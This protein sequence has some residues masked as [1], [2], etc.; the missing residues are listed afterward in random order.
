MEEVRL[1]LRI[2][3]SERSE[4]GRRSQ[5]LCWKINT[6]SPLD[7]KQQELIQELFCNQIGEG[8][9]LH[10]PVFVNLGRNVRI[11]RRCSI[12]NGFQC[13]AA[14]GLIIEDDVLI[15]LNCT[16]ATNNHDFYERSVLTCL[17]VHICRNAWLGV[18]VTICP[19]VT[20]GENAVI[21]AGS[22][23]T[24][25]IPANA[26]AAGVPARVIRYLDADQF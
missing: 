21:G 17:P 1:D 13:M 22:V 3:N 20:I 4:E 5:E 19:G 12:M 7:P 23:V 24:K 15:S 25:D 8:T 10:A 2:P 26:V 6:M 11:G 18:N 9:K 14:G 16:I